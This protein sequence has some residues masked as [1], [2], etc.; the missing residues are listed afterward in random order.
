MN[1]Q[2]INLFQ[3]ILRGRDELLKREKEVAQTKVHSRIREKFRIEFN[4]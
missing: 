1:I 2:S 4:I 3:I